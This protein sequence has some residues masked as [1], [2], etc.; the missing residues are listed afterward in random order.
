MEGRLALVQVVGHGTLDD[1]VVVFRDLGEANPYA[2]ED[3]LSVE[4]DVG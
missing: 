1:L 3:G 4:V 2:T